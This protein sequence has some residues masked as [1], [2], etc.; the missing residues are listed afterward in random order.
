MRLAVSQDMER[1]IRMHRLDW[2]KLGGGLGAWVGVSIVLFGCMGDDAST[3]TGPGGGDS[4][5]ADVGTT[6]DASGKEAASGLD[7]PSGDT[8]AQDSSVTDSA[9]A[10]D[11]GL[12]DGTASDAD[13][14]LQP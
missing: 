5:T 2:K 1:D 13:A 12:G 10:G 7:A 3:G 9:E 8:S 6:P 4:S 14:T 11:G